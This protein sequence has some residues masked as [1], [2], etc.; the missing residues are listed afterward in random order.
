MDAE[1]IPDDIKEAAR[2]VVERGY[3]EGL[4]EAVDLDD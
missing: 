4:I 2:R 1:R 3:N